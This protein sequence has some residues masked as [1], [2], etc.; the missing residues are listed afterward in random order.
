MANKK[1]NNVKHFSPKVFK[2]SFVYVAVVVVAIVVTFLL[3]R[4]T[5]PERQQTIYGSGFELDSCDV[6]TEQD[7]YELCERIFDDNPEE[8]EAILVTNK[9]H[10]HLGPNN[11]FGAK[12]ALYA[13]QLLNGEN[14]AISVR[15]EAGVQPP[16]SCLNDGIMAAIGSTFG[17]GLIANVEDSSSLAAT[18]TYEGESVRLEVK[19]EYSSYSKD[20]I[21]QAR[22]RYGGLNDDYFKEVRDTALE[23]WENMTQEELFIVSYP[24]TDS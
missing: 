6:I 15:S 9:F 23:V 20:R 11:I 7:I 24:A 2:G 4:Q 12:M 14:H 3:V 16:I 1:T 19:N 5:S 21:S 13:K 10:Q 8:F 17:R 18:F 22:E